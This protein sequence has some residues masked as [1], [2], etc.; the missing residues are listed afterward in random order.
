MDPHNLLIIV[1][2]LYHL[3]I[4]CQPKKNPN[5]KK[6]KQ[7]TQKQKQKKN[8]QTN[9]NI[10]TASLSFK[11]CTRAIAI[12]HNLHQMIYFFYIKIDICSKKTIKSEYPVNMYMYTVQS[13]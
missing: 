3:V 6:T 5:K 2:F 9:K 7:K 13:S 12:L 8:K 1:T 11:F 10:L 4:H